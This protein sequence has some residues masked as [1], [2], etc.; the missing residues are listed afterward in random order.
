MYVNSK[1]GSPSKEVTLLYNTIIAEESAPK[2]DS[3]LEFYNEM[4]RTGKHPSTG[5]KL[6]KAEETNAQLIIYSIVLQ[7]FVGA[8][9]ASKF[10]QQKNVAEV[11]KEGKL[12]TA[13]GSDNFDDSM[14]IIVKNLYGE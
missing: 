1:T 14:N 13:W 9:S 5:K 6:S 2:K 8:Y 4:I 11:S 10:N 7:P 3:R 12:V